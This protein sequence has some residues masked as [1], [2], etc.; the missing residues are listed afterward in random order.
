MKGYGTGTG[1]PACD[2]A[3]LKSH[4]LEIT[5]LAYYEDKDAEFRQH[6]EARLL[7][8]G[9]ADSAA[10]LNYLQADPDGPSEFDRLIERLT[11][12]ETHFFRHPEVFRALSE[13]VLPSWLDGGRVDP[14]RVWSAGCAHGPEA[15][16]LAIALRDGTRARGADPG[17]TI[18]GTDINRQALRRARRGEFSEWDL[19]GVDDGDRRRCFDRR[20]SCWV[21][22]EEYREGVEFRH[23][24]LVRDPFPPTVDGRGAFD[25]ILCRNV[26]M[27]FGAETMR[28]VVGR[29]FDSLVE[30]GWLV[31]GHAEPNQEVFSRFRTIEAP[32][33]LLY[34]KRKQTGSPEGGA[35]GRSHSGARYPAMNAEPPSPGVSTPAL[36][37][38]IAAPT[39]A[40]RLATIRELTDRG[41]IEAAAGRCRAWLV[42]DSMEP[43][44]YLCLAMILEKGGSIAEAMELIRKALYLDPA[45]AEGHYL[46]GLLWRQAGD[47]RRARREFENARRLLPSEEAAELH[48]WPGIS[49]GELRAGV[50]LQLS[51]TGTGG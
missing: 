47:M 16:S 45:L 26:V 50:A 49:A 27:Y 22:R 31:V 34:Q 46:L 18:V 33:A 12:G 5:G 3:R 35:E 32:G 36:P 37:A 25:L 9:L 44:A 21:V 8:R 13:T 1:D 4:V 40:E 11:I 51:G 23:H 10:Y 38:S 29:L 48:G 19:R 15:Y 41:A 39:V 7:E 2:D 20:D 30:G 24:N 28:R 17:W 43:S 42:E 14:L 6:I